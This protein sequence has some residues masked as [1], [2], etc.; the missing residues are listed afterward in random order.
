M[1]FTIVFKKLELKR[2]NVPYCYNLTST[3]EAERLDQ[4]YMAVMFL[5]ISIFLNE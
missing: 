1:Y 4:V 2:I 5:A 3:H